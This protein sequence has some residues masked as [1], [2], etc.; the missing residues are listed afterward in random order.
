[1]C[2]CEFMELESSHVSCPFQSIALLPEVPSLFYSRM[3]R[4]R[5]NRLQTSLW[6]LNLSHHDYFVKSYNKNNNL[7]NLQL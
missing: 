6:T 4:Q 2:E 5:K 7:V 1:M 3:V